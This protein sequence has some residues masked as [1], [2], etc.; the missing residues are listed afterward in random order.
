MQRLVLIGLTMFALGVGLSQWSG[1]PAPDTD[2]LAGYNW[3][4]SPMLSGFD[5]SRLDR[6]EGETALTYSARVSRAVDDAVYN[7]LD[8]NMAQSWLLGALAWI[9]V[10]DAGE[11]VL[12]P[13]GLRCGLC[14]QVAYVAARALT[15]AG[16]PAHPLGLNGHVVTAFIVGE[17]AYVIDPDLGV[18]PLQLDAPDLAGMATAL[19]LPKAGE[20]WTNVIVDIIASREDNEPYYNMAY[21]DQI[22]ERQGVVLVMESTLEIS[23]M[24]AGVALVAFGAALDVPSK[25]LSSPPSNGSTDS[26]ISGS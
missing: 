19:Y 14:H 4:P 13:T 10:T 3:S 1:G 22:A 17:N 15:N 7:C 11:G 12:A 24:I 21:L 23:L 18:G 9:G 16:I 6:R 25:R 5:D 8:L 20:E 26:T 2:G